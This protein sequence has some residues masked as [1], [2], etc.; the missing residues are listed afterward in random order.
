[1]QDLDENVLPRL[2]W[3]RYARNWALLVNPI[4][5]PIHVFRSPQAEEDVEE[6]LNNTKTEWGEAQAA[7]YATLIEQ[8][9]VLISM[10]PKIGRSYSHICRGV[11]G[12]H[13]K[14]S[15]RHILFYRIPARDRVEIVR[16]LYDSMDIEWE[17]KLSV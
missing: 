1:M 9:E 5:V 7:R 13:V 12:Y 4:G 16:C 17:L 3:T 8:T 11:R 6:A 2:S 14:G 15:S 10:H